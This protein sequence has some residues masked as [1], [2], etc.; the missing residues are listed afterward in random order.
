MIDRFICKINDHRYKMQQELRFNKGE[1]P[2]D[3]ARKIK[4]V[5]DEGDF[6]IKIACE[7]V[8]IAEAIASNKSVKIGGEPVN[9]GDLMLEAFVYEEMRWGDFTKERNPSVEEGQ[10][11]SIYL[12]YQPMKI[13]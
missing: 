11:Y 1:S 2:K 12:V 5:Y 13:D 7:D 4:R 3:L 6:S 8:N 10:P 9:L